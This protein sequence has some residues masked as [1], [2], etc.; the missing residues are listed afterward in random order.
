[1]LLIGGSGTGPGATG[2]ESLAHVLG[3]LAPDYEDR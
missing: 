2:L 1:M 3:G